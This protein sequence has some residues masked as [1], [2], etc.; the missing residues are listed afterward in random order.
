MNGGD[1][2][3]DMVNVSDQDAGIA[4]G[5]V[6]LSTGDTRQGVAAFF[7]SMMLV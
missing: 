4:N 5:G 7:I 3:A 2:G 1:Q 6:T